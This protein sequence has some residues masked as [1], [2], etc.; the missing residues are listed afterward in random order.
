MKIVYHHTPRGR[1]KFRLNRARAK[2]WI[3]VKQQLDQLLTHDRIHTIHDTAK[4]LRPTV[5]RVISLAKRFVETENENYFRMVHSY[6]TT[7][8]AINRLFLEILPRLEDKKDNYTRVRET[9]KRL[10]DNVQMGYIEIVGNAFERY[11]QNAKEVRQR[12]KPLSTW[13]DLKNL[14]NSKELVFYQNLIA[15]TERKLS[16]IDTVEGFTPEQRKEKERVLNA[17]AELFRRKLAIAEGEA[18]ILAS[19]KRRMTIFK[20]I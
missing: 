15:D 2:R 4:H 17:Q 9:T 12:E 6:V 11:E 20:A 7:K 14:S 18:R 1:V 8:F 16:E 10:G 5:E 13:R 19:E 3:L